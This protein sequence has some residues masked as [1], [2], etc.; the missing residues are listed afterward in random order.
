MPFSHPTPIRP[1]SAVTAVGRLLVRQG[2]PGLLLAH[3]RM[4]IEQTSTLTW[5][6][7][8][9]LAE[10]PPTAEV[11]SLLRV[12]GTWDGAVIHADSVTAQAA[13]P[14]TTPPAEEQ[15]PQAFVFSVLGQRVLHDLEQAGIISGRVVDYS[16]PQPTLKVRVTDVNSA[17]RIIERHQPEERFH[18]L[19]SR[20]SADALHT[21]RHLYQ[22][23]PD[24]ELSAAGESYDDDAEAHVTL[25][26]KVLRDELANAASHL[27]ADLVRI[28]SYV[29]AR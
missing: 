26:V 19:G 6:G 2:Q 25:T 7:A 17:Q 21:A 15:A 8:I 18:V 20:W 23:V 1:G 9:A 29:Q 5:S 28:T 27:P 4:T 13:P 12:D 11:G 3:Q 16:R 14:P 10:F 22:L 24:G